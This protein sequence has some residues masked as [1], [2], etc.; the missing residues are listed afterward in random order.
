MPG[1]EWSTVDIAG[2]VVHARLVVGADGRNSR[3]AEL[4]GLTARIT[5]NT[6]QI[7]I[8]TTA[9]MPAVGHTAWHWLSA[10]GMLALL[11]SIQGRVGNRLVAR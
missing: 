6:S 3:V 2:K 1:D 11:P 7:A 10:T 8:V 9:A 5:K 4:V